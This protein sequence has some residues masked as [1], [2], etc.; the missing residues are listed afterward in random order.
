MLTNVT[1]SQILE[2]SE[3]TEG[4]EDEDDADDSE[5]D[6]LRRGSDNTIVLKQVGGKGERPRIAAHVVRA[7][8]G[9]RCC[10][11]WRA[12]QQVYSTVAHNA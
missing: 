5:F 6:L 7:L 9:N 3:F 10:D 11:D 2:L 1:L 12:M 8:I 4:D